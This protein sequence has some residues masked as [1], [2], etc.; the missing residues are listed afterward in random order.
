MGSL[1]FLGVV[2]VVGSI[3]AVGPFTFFIQDIDE[4]SIS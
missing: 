4:C 2:L 3:S 1:S